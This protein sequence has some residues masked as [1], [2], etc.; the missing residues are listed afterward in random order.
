MEKKYTIDYQYNLKT[1]ARFMKP[2]WFLIVLL[3]LVV[4][5]KEGARLLD[6]F[7]FTIIIDQ[8]ALYANHTLTYTAFL[9]VL[10]SIAIA[11]TCTTLAKTMG[12]WMQIHLLNKIEG[13]SIF[14]LKR[15]YFN[16]ILHLSHN[17]HTTHKTGSL[18]ARLGRGAS[19]ME[20]MMDFIGFNIAPL[21]L[22]L[23]LVSTAFTTFNF[24]TAG[25][26]LI[27][28]SAFIGYT[29]LIQK[30]Q[31]PARTA[32][33]KAE[34]RE[35][36]VLGDMFTNIDAVKQ[37][38]KETYV[39]EKY[40]LY[41]EKTK[42]AL[43]RNW[44]WGRWN[45]AGHNLILALGTFFVLIIPLQEFL[46][47][48]ITVGSLVF[49][50]TTYLDLF[51]NMY[52]FSHGIRGFYRSM[53][54]FQDLFEYGKIQNEIKDI[55][56]AP[57]LTIEKG[58]IEFK[59][60]AFSYNKK[61]IFKDFS[62]EI[63]PNEKVALVG[64]SGSGKSTL[65][66][67][68]YRLYDLEKGRILIDGNDIKTVKQESL[69]SELA[70][71]PQ[72][73]VLFDDTIYN[74]ILFSNPQATRKEVFQAI[75]FAQLDT[76]IETFPLKENTVVGQRGV[77]LSGGEKQRV[78]IARALLANKRV[79]VLDEATSALD[80]QT[81]HDIQADLK[82]LLEGRTAIIIAHRLSTI[83][84]ADKIVVLDKG[85]IVQMG[86]HRQLIT[87][88]GRYRQLWNLQKGGYIKE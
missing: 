52:G 44:N 66:K 67:L 83:M 57:E 64:H 54:D 63:K 42:Q 7:F 80:S 45:D 77:K 31:E 26:I 47:G 32:E 4:L 16:H 34:D 21:F 56:N 62:L 50:Y 70:I 9:T 6:K 37:Y 17:F 2:S 12:N 11:Y 53:A 74:N 29:V 36:A 60:I 84:H 1:F 27:T 23:L 20:R 39:K 59:D 88:P 78:S 33:N 48:T 51:A 76:L 22:Q 82:K 24:Q 86:S 15:T 5:T 40:R 13:R 49:I 10:M 28:V 71:V 75:K 18:I 25:I 69:R 73:A 19:A 85:K 14:D 81:E 55:P 30:L 72:E 46:A 41:T 65:V 35:K 43:I 87:K 58:T 61:P 8:G 38:G 68:L 79:L 3:I